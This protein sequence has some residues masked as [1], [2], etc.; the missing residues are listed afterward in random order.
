MYILRRLSRTVVCLWSNL[1]T[2][3]L[4]H[5]SVSA[6][7]YVFRDRA[8]HLLDLCLVMWTSNTRLVNL[9]LQRL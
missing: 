6:L 8:L 5:L 9:L 3:S 4:H 2:L 7:L 1:T